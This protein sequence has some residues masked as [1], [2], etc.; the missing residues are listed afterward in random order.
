MKWCNMASAPKDEWI[1]V[2][3]ADGLPRLRQYV[4]SMSGW[5]GP[6]YISP[7]QEFLAWAPLVAPPW[8]GEVAE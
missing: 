5:V 7:S 1:F 8:T 4:T 3:G 2:V 6:K